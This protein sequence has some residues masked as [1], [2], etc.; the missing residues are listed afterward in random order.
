[1][2][3]EEVQIVI[4]H[5]EL[6]S[7]HQITFL[8]KH[9]EKKKA[10]TARHAGNSI[11]GID[12][13]L[14][15]LPVDEA[16]N[17]YNALVDPHLSTYTWSRCMHRRCKLAQTHL[18]KLECIQHYFVRRLLGLPTNSLLVAFFTETGLLRLKFR[19]LLVALNYLKYLVNLPPSRLARK[20]L[21]DSITLDRCSN[22]S[23]VR[24][25]RTTI[26]NLT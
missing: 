13:S 21:E 24:D 11:F 9:Y 18:S 1:M 23:W 17:L 25:L 14:G 7:A 12:D 16:L 26:A 20:A 10:I 8:L 15:F 3:N 4:E 22:H 2:G 6:R 5:M 19:R